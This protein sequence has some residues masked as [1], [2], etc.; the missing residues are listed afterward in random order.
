MNYKK[1]H[2]QIIAKAIDEHGH[3]DGFTW[4]TKKSG[5]HRH[6]INPKSLG[7]TNDAENLVYLTPKQ[8][9]TVHHLLI[10]F[11]GDCREMRQAYFF[12]SKSLEYRATSRQFKTAICMAHPNLNKVA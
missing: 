7:G 8:H 5:Y 3:P 11:L 9:F 10:R 12:M 1:I 4:R 6:H 2:D